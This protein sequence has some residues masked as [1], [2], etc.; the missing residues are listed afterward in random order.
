MHSSFIAG[1]P[2]FE[3]PLPAAVIIIVVVGGSLAVEIN[4]K[5]PSLSDNRFPLHNDLCVI[6]SLTSPLY[7]YIYTYTYIYI[8][9]YVITKFQIEHWDQYSNVEVI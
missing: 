6:L 3:P 8:Y 9:V 4:L 2:L 7:I 1:F 5:W